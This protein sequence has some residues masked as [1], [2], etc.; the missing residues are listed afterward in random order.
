MPVRRMHVLKH[1]GKCALVAMALAGLFWLFGLGLRPDVSKPVALPSAEEIRAAV[2]ARD[3]TL[4]MD[5]P[6]HLH[7]S[8][9]Y[10][11]GEN[12]AW[13][14][15]GEA[16]LLA[17]LVNAGTL[18][19]V[20]ERVGP[21]PVVLEGVDGIGQYGG[22]WIRVAS[23]L[24]LRHALVYE[25]GNATLNRWTP[26]GDT[27]VPNLATRIEASDDNRV[28]TVH[29]RKVNWSDGHPFTA[30]DV[31]FWWEGWAT[32]KDA[33]T[34]MTIGMVP[35]LVKIKGEYGRI[36]KV[37]RHTVRYVFPHPYGMFPEYM[38]T[39]R[40]SAF[41]YLP[42]HYLE[43]FHPEYGDQALIAREMERYKIKT[44]QGLF[45]VMR[46]QDNPERPVMSAWMMRTY[47]T[48]GPFTL[49]RN[50]YYFAVDTQG[51][52]LPY[53]DRI[54]VQIKNSKMLGLSIANGDASVS[55]ADFADYSLLMAQKERKGY[56]VRHWYSAG[57][58]AFVIQPNLNRFVDPDKP[59]TGKKAKLLADVRFRKALSYAIDRQA[60]IDAVWNGVGEPSQ[61]AP[62]RASV[63]Y[64]PALNKA[65]IEYDVDRADALLEELGLTARDSDGF[66]MFADGSRMV[67][68]MNVGSSG[69]VGA[70]AEFVVG[71]WRRVG[72][73]VIMRERAGPL[74]STE[75]KSRVAD[76]YVAGDDATHSAV[77][78]RYIAPQ[79]GWS[80]WASGWGFWYYYDGM[81]DNPKARSKICVR[82]PDDHPMM[83]TFRLLDEAFMAGDP[84]TRAEV[85]RP[86]LDLAA[87]NL[88]TIS[89][90]TPPPQ[91][92][93][94]D[95]DMRGVPD[96]AL[97][98]FLD[99][100]LFNN[101]YPETW[102]WAEP[103]DTAA[104]RD[105]IKREIL[106]PTTR[107]DLGG[108][109]SKR[110]ASSG[111]RVGKV[112]GAVVRWCF[113]VI[114]VGLLGMVAVKHPFVG[115]R[116]MLMVPT[117]LVISVVVFTIIQIPPGSY[118]DTYLNE[119][120]MRGETASTDQIRD[121][122]E[123][124][125]LDDSM[126]SRYMHWMGFMWFCPSE[127]AAKQ[128]A[129]SF[130][131]R[132]GWFQPVNKGLLQG[133]LGLAMS[134]RQPV[135]DMVGDRI[136][137]TFVMSLGTI[138]FTWIMALPIGIYSATRQYSIGDYI[139]TFFGF[140]GVCVP[141]FLLALILVYVSDH[142]WGIEVTG[143]F[144]KE[145]A[146]QPH[147]TW[148][149]VLDLLKHIWLPVV[150]LGIGG[151]AGM[152][153]VM[154]ANL[155]DE[156]KKPYVVT[157]RAKGVRPLKLLLK[158]PVR[159]ALNPFVSGIGGI[160]P[161]LISGGAIVGII[162]SLPTVGP[163]MLEAVM[164]EDT[165][166]AGSMLMVLSLLG[167]AGVLVSDLLLLWVDPR[168]RLGKE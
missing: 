117:L 38:A 154:R 4:P 112:L 34:G 36:E 108:V 43:Q 109:A 61:V 167:V 76:F 124:F 79:N 158:Y 135:N 107:V 152:I 60:I 20:A 132:H 81:A 104:V 57:S 114:G 115:R 157:A 155:L 101:A 39:M 103:S 80:A 17:E 123:M 77:S 118:I 48:T 127:R 83:T 63:Y 147:W 22:T 95:K 149:K 82:P 156:L 87:E 50:P 122:R 113:I 121:I 9:D 2:A 148:A 100:G 160:F 102:Y 73:R 97:Y 18:P 164:S 88:W 153:R 106:T 139:L 96:K 40:A 24:N 111:E 133:H 105:E 168:I 47:R 131:E 8:V 66:R 65:C 5:K 7:R 146:L 90:A 35:E 13:W 56:D 74:A 32:W 64:H 141:Q 110:V 67:F 99:F 54:V 91:I 55:Y 42:K 143:L 6:L 69:G 12:A 93:V 85:F 68:F 119:L 161:R 98:G 84:H 145:F 11:E 26:Y 51:N 59:E 37:D 53:L 70:V 29:L 116:L 49:V 52:Q 27:L 92:V 58:S 126:A 41:A 134:T 10:A 162:M 72:V 1:S 16:P 166:L 71:Y 62:G 165:Y 151:T 86:A 46:A 94:V 78:S 89:I 45:G 125:R 25:L 120:E 128:D 129:E 44:K 28:F 159:L 142:Y 130:I 137:L 140:I 136:L 30:D 144:S 163:M 150:V 75:I 15:K 3:N 23:S 19:P 14:P 138:L 21:E 31:M 33:K